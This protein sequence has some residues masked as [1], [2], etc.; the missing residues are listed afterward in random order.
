M[1]NDGEFF[2]HRATAERII[3]ENDDIR[4]HLGVVRWLEIIYS[5]NLSLLESGDASARHTLR[6]LQDVRMKD[7]Q[8]LVGM[9]IF[10]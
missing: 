4:R 1:E 5:E 6:H 3:E 10:V 8:S 7:K 9:G 2:S